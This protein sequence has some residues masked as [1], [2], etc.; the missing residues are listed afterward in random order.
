MPHRGEDLWDSALPLFLL[1]V[2]FHFGVLRP[3]ADT[4]T[5]STKFLRGALVTEQRAIRILDTEIAKL[6]AQF[7]D[8]WQLKVRPNHPHLRGEIFGS[9]ASRF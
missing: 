9:I 6:F 5:D 3:L 7:F 1:L 2:Q 8:V 4:V